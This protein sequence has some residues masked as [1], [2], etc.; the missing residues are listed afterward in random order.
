MMLKVVSLFSGVGGLDFGF[1]AAGFETTVAVDTDPVACRTLRLNR[2][3]PVIEGNIAAV[4]SRELLETAGLRVG[5][6]DVLIGGPPCKPF[7]KSGYWATGDAKR[8]RDPRADTLT[9]SFRILRHILPKAFLL[10][11]VPGLAYR[12]KS[13]A[14]DAICRELEATN[15]ETSAQY[16]VCVQALSA[17][18][19][20]VPQIRERVFIVGSRDGLTFRFPMPTHAP[21]EEANGKCTV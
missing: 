19:F 13:E 12:G 18:D 16:T 11:N 15:A 8:L 10:E 1:E 4:K 2:S 9:Q 17:A 20:G 7:S 5:E 21:P 6:A 3:W 14:V